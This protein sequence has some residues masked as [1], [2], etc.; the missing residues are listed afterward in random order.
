MCSFVTHRGFLV[1]QS[2]PRLVVPSEPCLIFELFVQ[3]C[4]YQKRQEISHGKCKFIEQHISSFLELENLET[5]VPIYLIYSSQKNIHF[6][7]SQMTYWLARETALVK[8]IFCSW[9]NMFNGL[10]SNTEVFFC[11]QWLI[12]SFNLGS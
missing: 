6:S 8:L 5:Y 12:K 7:R 10:S 9:L 2:N 4:F 11:L 3:T 1:A